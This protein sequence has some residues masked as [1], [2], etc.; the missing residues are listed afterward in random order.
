MDIKAI[1]TRYK[2]YR[3]RS[4]TEARWAVFFDSM[5]LKWEYEPQGF[6]LPSG[7]YLPDFRVGGLGWFEIKPKSYIDD[8]FRLH[9]WGSL[10]EAEF[11]RQPGVRGGVL[12]GDPWVVPE[13]Y[14]MWDDPYVG[15]SAAG[16]APYC[17][18][19]CREC[20][21]VGFQFAGRAGRNNHLQRCSLFGD[22]RDI[23]AYGSDTARLRTAYQAARQARFEHSE[24]PQFA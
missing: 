22:E 17:F 23:K 5:G 2:G 1:E 10:K 20:G 24:T 4:R 16:D 19:E 6:V 3:F 14:D 9:N 8:F 13:G 15:I 7:G 18:C 21:S 11:F 12:A